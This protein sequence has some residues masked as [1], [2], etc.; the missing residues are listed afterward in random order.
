[1][2][3]ATCSLTHVHVRH[4]LA[5]ACLDVRQKKVRGAERGHRGEGNMAADH[6]H[7]LRAGQAMVSLL[8]LREREREERR[9][10]QRPI[11]AIQYLSLQYCRALSHCNRER[12][13][14]ILLAAPSMEWSQSYLLQSGGCPVP[15]SSYPALPW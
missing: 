3:G 6:T 12:Y 9:S 1:M 10:L 11:R 14:V 13:N 8:Q 4:M 5:H 2:Y 15:A 7:P